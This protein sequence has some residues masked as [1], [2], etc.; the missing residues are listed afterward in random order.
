MLVNAA[1][2][3]YFRMRI[4]PDI[5]SMIFG[6]GKEIHYIGGAEILQS[7]AASAGER[8]GERNDQP[9]GHGK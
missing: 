1:L 5:R 3:H 7:S 8:T 6:N 4:I 2:P 9:A